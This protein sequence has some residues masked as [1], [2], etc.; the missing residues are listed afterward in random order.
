MDRLMHGS[1]D[2][3]AVEYGDYAFNLPPMAKSQDVSV[4][5][6]ALGQSG[7]FVHSVLAKPIYEIRRIGKHR[8]SMDARTSGCEAS[9]NRPI[10]WG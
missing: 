2:L 5:A 7:C 6:A 10:R 9:K 8:S 4:A 1:Q 3:F